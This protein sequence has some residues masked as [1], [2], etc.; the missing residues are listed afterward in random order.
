MISFSLGTE[1]AF[2]PP[3]PRLD[4]NGEDQSPLSP[5]D[6]EDDDHLLSPG[7]AEAG[8]PWPIE[9]IVP[10]TN[11]NTVMGQK[12]IKCTTLVRIFEPS[13]NGRLFDS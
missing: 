7:C 13:R 11:V 6:F 2:A 9:H 1:G 12:Q 8:L 5:P 10:S 4:E 3:R